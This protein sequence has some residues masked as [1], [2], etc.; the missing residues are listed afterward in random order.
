MKRYNWG[1]KE[2]K[3]YLR[4][5]PSSNIICFGSGM[6]AQ[7]VRDIF[8]QDELWERVVC[9]VDNDSDKQKTELAIGDS[10]FPIVAPLT[11][12]EERYASD[13]I[14][15]L[16]EYTEAIE[17]QLAARADFAPQAYIVYSDIN[18]RLLEETFNGEKANLYR[19]VQRDAD[20]KIPPI[21]HYCWFGREQMPKEQAAYLQTWRRMCPD[22]TIMEWNELN[23]DLNVC[24]YVREAYETG[25]YAFVSD[26]VRM[27]VIYQYG[28]I[29]F[30][31]DVELKKS[32][33]WL[34]KYSAFFSYGK[35]PA[36]NSGCG[37]GAVPRSELIKEMRD[38]P[39]K[40]IP[41][42]RE[43][44]KLNRTTNCYY[45]SAVLQKHGFKMDFSTQMIE[46]VLVLS[47]LFFPSSVH[48]ELIQTESAWIMAQHYDV[49]SWRK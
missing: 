28:G 44:G 23:Y 24:R 32:M 3:A 46:D 27:D 43:D 47:P 33:D 41:F 10:T 39:R 4:E 1:I 19:L 40:N 21:I 29:Y 34:R 36:V 11:L 14:I 18:R 9:F 42:V 49:G 12:C 6:V 20:T 22:Y 2:L 16:A 31:T 37:F 26:Y 25:N 8:Q 30:D 45:E 17:A 13:I 15:I 5:S 48:T 7:H 38:C 35:W